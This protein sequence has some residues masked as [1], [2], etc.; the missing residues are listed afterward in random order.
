MRE[1]V[2]LTSLLSVRSRI[3][4]FLRHSGQKL[5]QTQRCAETWY[6]TTEVYK[7]LKAVSKQN[8]EAKIHPV[9]TTN[10]FKII[11]QFW[12]TEFSV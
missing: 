9:I 10:V 11:K 8:K 2:R 7:V 5:G 12:S 4:S 6:C 3:P 1:N